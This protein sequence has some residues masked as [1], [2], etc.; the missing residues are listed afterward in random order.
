MILFFT[1]TYV[2]VVA[3]FMWGWA[4]WQDRME[5]MDADMERA[6]GKVDE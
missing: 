1:F 5:A 6:Y 2:L 3:L 4:R